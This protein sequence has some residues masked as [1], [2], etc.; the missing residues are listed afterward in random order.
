MK[1]HPAAHFSEAVA[2]AQ[3]TRTDDVTSSIETAPNQCKPQKN[4][5]GQ[6]VAVTD[7][8]KMSGQQSTASSANTSDDAQLQEH[9][10][11]EHPRKKAQTSAEH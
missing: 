7:G 4:S 5:D 9:T 3:E 10:D 6:H 11:E 2:V 8:E 1:L